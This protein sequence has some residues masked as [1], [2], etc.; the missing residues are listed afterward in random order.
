[1]T[2]EV[3]TISTVHLPVPDSNPVVLQVRQGESKEVSLI[4]IEVKGQLS[5]GSRL[6]SLD[7][8]Q[9]SLLLIIDLEAGRGSS[10]P[11]RRAV[12]FG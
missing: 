1:M 7:G 8:L 11:T 12:S 10:Q 9:P 6:A 2:R 4:L 3:K 5:L